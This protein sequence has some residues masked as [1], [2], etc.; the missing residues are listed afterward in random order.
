MLV[1]HITTGAGRRLSSSE[2]LTSLRAANSF[3]GAEGRIFYKED[4]EEGAGFE[5]PIVLKRI[6]NGGISVVEESR[7]W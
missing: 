2:L 6:E 1:G 7:N 3:Q 5:Y 4:A